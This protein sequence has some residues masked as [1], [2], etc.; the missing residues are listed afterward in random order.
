MIPIP[1]KIRKEIQNDESYSIC[2][3]RDYP[4][5]ICGGR[6]TLEHAIESK[7]KRLQEKWAIIPI[8]ARAHEVDEFQ[9]A[10]TMSKEL[11]IWVALNR[12]TDDELI[13]ISKADD[14]IEMRAYLNNKYGVFATPTMFSSEIMYHI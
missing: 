10:G 14:Y 5:H 3:L 2:S 6:I 12:A 13:A 4:G 1:N 8:C 11:N 9:D 7:G